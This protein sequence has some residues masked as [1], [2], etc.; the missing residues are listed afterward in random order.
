MQ[1]IHLN[2]KKNIPLTVAA[3]IFILLFVAVFFLMQY[4]QN[5][6][7]SD[8]RINLTEIVTQNKDVISSKF[9]VEINNLETSAGQIV[10]RYQTSGST[11][12]EELGQILLTYSKEKADDRLFIA[13]ADGIAFF[14]SGDQINISGRKYFQ[15]ALAGSPNISD[16]ITSRLDGEEKFI[17]SVPLVDRGKTIGT[18]QKFYSPEEMYE[19]CSISLFSSQ[20]Y[21]YIINSDGYILISSKGTSYTQESDNYYRTIY[22]QGNQDASKLL[23][24]DIKAEKSGF[25]ETTIDGVKTFSAY[26]PLEDIHDW[27]LISSVPTSAVSP[28][29][30]IVVEMFYFIL[31]FVV[32]IFALFILYFMSYK[33]KQQKTLKHIAFFDTVTHGNT[34]NKFLVDLKETLRTN[35]EKQYYFISFDIDNFRY[36][37]GFY[38]FDFGDRVLFKINESIGGKLLPDEIIA[39]AA[40]DHFVLLLEDASEQRLGSLLSF[41]DLDGVTIYISAGAYIITDPSESVNLMMDKA[42]TA[43]RS[44]KGTLHKT[45][46]FYS[47]KFD[48]QLIKNEQLKRALEHAL[49]NGE[50]IPFYQ[51]K[52][53]VNTLELVGA[54]ALA[55][56]RTKDGKLVQ[57]NDFIPLAEKTGLIADLDMAVFEQVLQFLKKNLEAGVHCVPISVNFSRLHL[58]DN[59]FIDKLVSKTDEYNVPRELIEIEIT[60]SVIF[61]NHQL[62]LDFINQLHEKGFKISMDDF[63]SGY[64]SL[65]M[66][67]DIPIDIL[68]IDR[69]FLKETANSERQRVIFSAIAHM[70]GQLDIGIVA[71]GVETVENTELMKECGCA[72]AQGYYFAKPMDESDFENIYRRGIL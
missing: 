70:A 13:D 17:I 43:A 44:A 48:Q 63:G 7:Y 57:P 64:S 18:L 49:E 71:E 36:I 15:I 6:L 59:R 11:E 55:R 4:V 54:E 68:K 60:E 61:D 65:N 2:I 12:P 33:N 23:E 67:K 27:F 45:V 72:V 21:M 42:T 39:R 47:E 41:V 24:S 8:V 1:Q 10:E 66:L 69:E 16:R 40:N 28:N 34:F 3:I 19:L 32:A 29:A 52:V 30:N 22:A 37:N 25:M 5:L 14:P 50:I 51:P 46:E 56:W 26:T 31:L 62:I 20:G 58:L 9:Q 35:P 38:G 53:D